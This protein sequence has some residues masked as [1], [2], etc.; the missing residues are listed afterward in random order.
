MHIVVND[1]RAAYSDI[2][3]DLRTEAEH[4]GIPTAQTTPPKAPVQL[5][6]GPGAHVIIQLDPTT[7]RAIFEYA[8]ALLALHK[9][10]DYAGT[11]FKAV[12]TKL[13]DVTGA[14][15]I[16]L[17]GKTWHRLYERVRDPGPS[18]R[19]TR[20]VVALESE[21]DGAKLVIQNDVFPSHAATFTE[22]D[23]TQAYYVMVAHALPAMMRVASEARDHGVPL[24]R[25]VA[26]LYYFGAWRW[27][28]ELL[29][30]G[31]FEVGS[32]GILRPV[33]PLRGYKW[34]LLTR[35]RFA[36]TGLSLADIPAIV[37]RFAAGA[38]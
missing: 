29:P 32:R 11:F 24:T 5:D 20:V 33:T 35:W 26:V 23:V 16:D 30:I 10:A 15:I 38:T 19:D 21:F 1:E 17:L 3:S 37:E 34:R 8:V 22:S 2:I 28:I 14:K 4:I 6:S 13:G 25:A 18:R 12:I 27:Y 31:A 36:K 9:S 7:L